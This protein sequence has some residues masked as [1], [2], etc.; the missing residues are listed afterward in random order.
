MT[1]RDMGTITENQADIIDTFSFFEDWTERYQMLISMGQ[2]LTFPTEKQTDAYLVK[3]CQSQVWFDAWYENGVMHYQ[4]ISDSTIVSG[5]LAVLLKVYNHQP[6]QAIVDTPA[7][8]IRDIGFEN[9]LSPTRKN[10]LA[11]MLTTLKQRAK[12]VLNAP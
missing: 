11:A 8:F 5:L 12:D 4:G 10:G 6:P 3:G 1:L 7:D 2:K 9:H